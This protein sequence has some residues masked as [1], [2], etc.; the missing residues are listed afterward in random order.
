MGRVALLLLTFI[1]LPASVF[2]QDTLYVTDKLFLGLYPKPE[3][4]G[5]ALTTLVSG[6]P[7]QVLERGKYYSRVRTA[8]GVE[9]WVKS[10]YLVEEK[11][12]RQMLNELETQRD[13][14]AA[15]LKQTQ[16]ELAQLREHA[17]SAD[18]QLQE[19]QSGTRQ[20]SAQLQ[21]LQTENRS[22][23]RRLDN[24]GIS[25][26]LRWSVGAAALCL[27]LGLWAGYA[28]ID[29]RIRRRHGGFRLH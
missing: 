2:A 21:R 27:L 14:L 17:A 25:V 4:G 12:P 11:P 28:W 24:K 6:T 1:V 9:G 13:R 5:D 26:P 19:L 3:A 8:E 29:F 7:L 20:R 23:Q 10:A 22:L 18:T 16:D 15:Q